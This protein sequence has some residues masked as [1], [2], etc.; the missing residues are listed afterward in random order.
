MNVNA[1]VGMKVDMV[2]GMPGMHT[3]MYTTCCCVRMRVLV[4]GVY[5][6][7]AR[8]AIHYTIHRGTTIYK[9]QGA[10]TCARPRKRCGLQQLRYL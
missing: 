1:H 5:G 9:G 4:H 6:D 7:S 10:L 2:M 3:Q 8:N